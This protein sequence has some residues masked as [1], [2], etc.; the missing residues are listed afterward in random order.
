[1]LIIL[2]II[3]IVGAISFFISLKSGDLFQESPFAEQ[4]PTIREE[5]APLTVEEEKILQVSLQ[6]TLNEMELAFEEGNT[7][8]ALQLA[9]Q[10]GDVA[11][12][13]NLPEAD[14]TRVVADLKEAIQNNDRETFNRIVADIEVE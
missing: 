10:V 13:A 4:D 2:L 5:G 7:N 1:L 8:R 3:L 11:R 14:I 12:Q 9:E 6:N